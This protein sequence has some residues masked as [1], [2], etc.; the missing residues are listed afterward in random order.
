MTPHGRVAERKTLSV[1]LGAGASVDAGMPTTIG[2]TEEVIERLT[3]RGQIGVLEFV[4]HTIAADLAQ[5][6]PSPRS[7][8]GSLDV[9]VDVE[10]LFA[11]VELLA[12]RL[13]QPLAPFVGAWHPGLE[14]FAAYSH[15]TSFFSKNSLERAF[16]GIL[17]SGGTRRLIAEIE[18]FVD[19]AIARSRGGDVSTLLTS[20]RD[21]MLRS[22]FD[23]LNIE[24]RARVQYL[25]PLIE[26]LRH[27]SSLTIA[28]LNYDR[29]IENASELAD[30]TCHTGIETWLT[31][32]ALDWPEDGLRLLKL[33]GSIDWVF[34][35]E[36][37]AP[38]KL[39]RLAIR[40]V[41]G[42]DEKARYDAPAVVFGEAGKLRAEGPFLEL[43]LAWSAQLQQVNRLLVVGYSF[44]D[45]HV[46][47]LIARWFNGGTI[48]ESSCSTQATSAREGGTHSLP[49]CCA[50]MIQARLRL[51]TPLSRVAHI[52]ATAEEGLKVAIA[53]ALREPEN[54]ATA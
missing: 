11:T 9:A 23:I 15:D 25:V 54:P 13:A 6:E 14:K 38:G 48:A 22:L 35:R 21:E 2:M 24:D 20:A 10:R 40:K 1:L 49:R 17:D 43:L 37:R 27:Q 53:E 19:G 41:A 32:G 39:P 47:E 52:Q 26:L 5:R 8:W 28:T 50:S 7:P 33:H 18:R 45:T 46:N 12:A 4:R 34:E 42:L 3:D 30:K 51:P 31:G 16:N 44:R 36:H 29:S